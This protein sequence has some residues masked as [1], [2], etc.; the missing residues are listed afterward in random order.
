MRLPLKSIQKLQLAQNAI[1]QTVLG[2]PRVAHLTFLLCEL[3][4][5]PLCFWVQFKVLAIAYKILWHVSK[6]L[7]DSSHPNG[8]DGAPLIP[9]EGHA[10]AHFS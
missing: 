1:A 3:H 2:G 7:E 5:L 6:L 10:A 8:I 4:W 9:A